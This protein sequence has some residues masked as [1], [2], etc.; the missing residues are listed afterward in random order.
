MDEYLT[1]PRVWSAGFLIALFLIIGIFFHQPPALSTFQSYDECLIRVTE[2]KYPYFS[3][4]QHDKAIAYCSP[5]KT[6]PGK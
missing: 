2:G 4:F 3:T 6:T 1:D 5:L